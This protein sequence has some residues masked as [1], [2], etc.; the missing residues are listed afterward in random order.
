M[1]EQ[2]RIGHVAVSIASFALCM[3]VV[4]CIAFPTR[5]ITRR[6]GSGG[7]GL[8][9]SDVDLTFIKIGF[10]PRSEIA[11]RLRAIDVNSPG[12]IFWGRW[13]ES[14]WGVVGGS[15][16]PLSTTAD[17]VAGSARH[18]H[19]RNV[20][21]K[22][23]PQGIAAEMQRIDNDEALWRQLLV[24]MR[25]SSSTPM[26]DTVEISSNKKKYTRM[27]LAANSV[28]LKEADQKDDVV[29]GLPGPVVVR[30]RPRFGLTEALSSPELTCFRA[31][32]TDTHTR[33][34]RTFDSC[35][36]A[37]TFLEMLAHLD[38]LP[39]PARWSYGAG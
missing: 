6:Y 9:N 19:Y 21:I 25:S 39:S 34:R 26:S 1:S 18:W 23:D 11:T 13:I 20:L 37:R 22:F 36:P 28:E 15:L 3:A 4:G 14:S 12:Q 33:R 27:I 2:N 35:A 31:E 32:I 5:M 38:R 7:G 10:T 16:P 24:Y 30:L 29:I 17:P 8:H